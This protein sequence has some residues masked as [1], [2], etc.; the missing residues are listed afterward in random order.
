M[1]NFSADEVGD[2]GAGEQPCETQKDDEGA[3]ESAVKDE[4]FHRVVVNAREDKGKLQADEDED[5]PVD[6]GGE[7][8]PEAVGLQADGGREETI[9][10]AAEI[11]AAGDDSEDAGCVSVF[12]GEIRGVGNHDAEG[13]FDGTVVEVAFDAL[14]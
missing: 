1:E 11:E 5:E 10:A 3:E 2:K 12:G 8:V 13:D 14:N 7:G 9:F 6:G 4:R